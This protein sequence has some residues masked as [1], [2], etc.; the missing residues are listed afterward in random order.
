MDINAIIENLTPG[1]MMYYGGFLGAGVSFLLILIC[2]IVFPIRRKRLL[3]KLGEE[4]GNDYV[5]L[6]KV[7][8]RQ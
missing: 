7:K 3:K 6:L 8:E 5:E 2:L 4:I 1:A